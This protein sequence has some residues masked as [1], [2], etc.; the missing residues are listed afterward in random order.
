MACLLADLLEN[1]KTRRVEERRASF[2][3]PDEASEPGNSRPQI[4]FIPKLPLPIRLDEGASFCIYFTWSFLFSARLR[5]IC[6]APT[7]FPDSITP[8]TGLRPS[9]RRKIN[10]HFDVPTDQTDLLR[11]NLKRRGS[12]DLFVSAFLMLTPLSYWF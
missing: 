6:I 11:A 4:A 10:V 9:G 3:N 12:D 5:S 1:E 8:V 7:R 2:G